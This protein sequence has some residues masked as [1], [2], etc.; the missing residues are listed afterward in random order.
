MQI[1]LLGTGIVSSSKANKLKQMM[2]M[3]TVIL[4]INVVASYLQYL[5]M[6]Y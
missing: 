5:L 4:I 6:W 3:W 2:E 1:L